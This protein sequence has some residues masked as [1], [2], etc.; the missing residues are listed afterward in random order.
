M[1]RIRL[2]NTND[3]ASI[4]ALGKSTFDVYYRHLFENQA[5]IDTYLANAFNL[6]KIYNSLANTKNIYWIAEEVTSNIKVGY[7]KL[8]QN[9]SADIIGKGVG[10][11]LQRIYVLP[12]FESSGIGMQMQKLIEREAIDKG[13]DYVWLSTLKSNKGAIRFYDR[14]GY[15]VIGE[16]Q[17]TIGTQTFEHWIL[18]KNLVN[19]S[20]ES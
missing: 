12:G 10:C 16:D 20:C 4:V 8:Q 1:I 19:I 13:N 6:E 9:A 11:K 7:A 17:Y 5:D 3:A 15:T 18:A 14:E 2:A